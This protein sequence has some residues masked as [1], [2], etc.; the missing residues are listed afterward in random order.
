MDYN[1]GEAAMT[2]NLLV[3]IKGECKN[4]HVKVRVINTM[5]HGEEMKCVKGRN[6]TSQGS[7]EE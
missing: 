4:I 7:A 3:I 5:R 6:L 2:L 1:A